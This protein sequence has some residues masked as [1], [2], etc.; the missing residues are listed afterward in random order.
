M[1]S[2]LSRSSPAVA[3][4]V[5]L[6]AMLPQIG[7]TASPAPGFRAVVQM[8]AEHTA[9]IEIAPDRTWFLAGTSGAIA[10]RDMRTGTI[11]R[12]LWAGREAS[13]TRMAISSDGGSVF[14]R[15][16]RD[17]GEIETVGWSAATGFPVEKA[18]TS[19]PS[20]EAAHWIWI[21]HKWPVSWPLATDG[22]VDLAAEK[23]YLVAQKLALPFELE[24]VE[25]IEPTDRRD[26]IQVTTVGE[27]RDDLEP[28]DAHAVPS[29]SYHVYFVDVVRKAIVADISGKTLRTDCGAPH[30]A[31]AFDGH[32]LLLAPTERDASQSNVNALLVDLGPVPPAVIWTWP[33]QDTQVSDIAFSRGLIVVRKTPDQAT[34][35]DPLTAR[36]IVHFDH[37][38]GSD[39]LAWSDD[40]TTFAVG[41]DEQRSVAEARR[42]GVE[43]VRS[44]RKLFF[45]ADARILEIRLG[46]DGSRIFVRTEAGW[47]A[48]DASSGAKLS[49]FVVPAAPDDTLRS[50]P[51]SQLKIVSAYDGVDP[52]PDLTSSSVMSI[53]LCDVASG[54]SLW[55]ATADDRAESRDILIVQHPDGRVLVSE[56]GA[57]LVKLVNAFDVRSFE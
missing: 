4:L 12:E 54:R 9:A 43:A 27:A 52:C 57:D 42:Y 44:G 26:V 41:F 25:S 2:E 21:E 49:S 22:P 56:G 53:K 11:L 45:P 50:P 18:G 6:L 46:H 13:F 16:A 39:V 30:G 35:W 47:A 33:C 20:L 10:I 51:G 34:I 40:L 8:G 37:I 29:W 23:Q 14:A 19:A 15:L 31:F 1:R 5:L 48:W 24:K 7:R 28:A 38:V 17:A 32:H 55:L 36:R 3:V